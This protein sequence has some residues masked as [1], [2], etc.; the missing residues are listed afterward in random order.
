MGEKGFTLVELIAVV[1]L[2]TVVLGIAGYS[3]FGI[4]NNS[5]KKSEGLFVQEID[6]AI[7]EYIGLYGGSLV[8]GTT[9][10][11][12]NSCRFSSCPAIEELETE[13][14]DKDDYYEVV[15]AY[16]VFYNSSFE[17]V[18][19]SFLMEEDFFDSDKLINPVNKKNCLDEKD[20]AIRIFKDSNYVYYYYVDLSGDNTS[21]EISDEN[22]IIDT[23]P[24]N[25]KVEVGI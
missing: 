24:D 15:D 7:S 20:L 17:N 25:L 18:R 19:L 9:K 4:I 16:E 10:Y 14:I 2:I 3:V 11:T 8:K 21:C 23:L 6:K 5:K 13:G 12:F 22:G 1:V